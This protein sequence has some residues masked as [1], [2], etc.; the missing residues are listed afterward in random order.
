MRVRYVSRRSFI[1][2]LGIRPGDVILAINGVEINS[3]ED[4]FSAFEQLKNEDTVIITVL[5]KGKRID[6]KYELE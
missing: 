6:L 3:P 4:S 1:H 5:R 2:K